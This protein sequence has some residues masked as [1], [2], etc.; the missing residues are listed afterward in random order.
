MDHPD[1]TTPGGRLRALR[2]QK[3]WSQGDLAR[4]VGADRQTVHR[5]ESTSAI[6]KKSVAKYAKV[7]GI[8]EGWLLY[9][10]GDGP[11]D[12]ATEAVDRYLASDFGRTTPEEVRRRLRRVS[13]SAL[14]IRHLTPEVVH[15]VRVM[16]Q[17]NLSDRIASTRESRSLSAHSP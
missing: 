6:G 12:T 16:I 1:L 8:S 14:G 9:G 5:H 3:N 4:A 7:F 15:E 11:R 2:L 13:Y 17:R 10:E